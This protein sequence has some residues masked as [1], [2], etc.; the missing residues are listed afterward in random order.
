MGNPKPHVVCIPYPS[1][2]HVTPMMRLAKLLHSRGFHITFVNTEFNHKRLVRAKGP[3]SVKGFSDFR[4]EAIPDGLPPSDRDA[5]QDIPKLCDSTRKNCLVPFKEL[6]GK[7]NSSPELPRVTCIISDGVM[8]FGIKAAEEMGIPEVQFWTSPACAMMCFLHYREFINRGIC[9]FKDDNYLTDG[10]LDKPID[11]IAGMKNIRYKDVPSFIRTTDPND[12]MFDFIGEEAQNCL[13]AP[14]I[15]FNTFDAFEHQ[16]LQAYASK[17][18][19][20]NIYTIGPLP[21]LGR[22]VPESPVNSLN[23]SLWKPDSKCLEWLDKKEKDSVL[24]I[25]YGSITTMTEQHLIEF[26]WGIAN[27]KHPFLWI[28]RPDIVT[29]DSDSASLPREFLEET[30]EIGMLAT[31]CAQDQVLAHPAVGA[32]LTH[33]GWNSMMETVCEGVPVI[34]WPFFSD[35][36]TNCRYSCTEW[37]IGMEVNEDVRREEVELLVKEMMGGEKGKELRRKA[38][39]WKMLAEE[40]TNVGG[41]SY[42]NF[43]RFIK[44]ALHYEG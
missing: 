23:S 29:G 14:A 31:W 13:K 22:H 27:S 43:D 21:L 24:Y 1:Q 34:G 35:Q 17:F 32:F 11:W 40:A 20:R 18:N 42:Q 25:N 38:K 8:S 19:Y 44:E 16:V 15:I 37:G 4:F 2:G 6:L 3:Q 33:C 36:Q 39:E 7:L 41:S 28:V 10:T 30:K 12:I 9:P 26:A 5:T